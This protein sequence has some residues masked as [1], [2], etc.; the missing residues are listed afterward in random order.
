MARKEVKI[1]VNS[2]IADVAPLESGNRFFDQLK[3]EVAKIY[4]EGI[5]MGEAEKLAAKFLHAQMQVS[6]LI[7]GRDLDTRLKKSGVETIESQVLL[8]ETRK[9][10]K[11]PS[12]SILNATAATDLTVNAAKDSYYRAVTETEGL[13]RLYDMLHEAHIYCRGIAKGMNG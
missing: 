8:E 4:L 2:D 12:E 7:Q 6:E 5:T 3:A 10:E 1:Q 11:K 9:H 13:K